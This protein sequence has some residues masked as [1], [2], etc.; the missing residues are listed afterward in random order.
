MRRDYGVQRE[1]VRLSLANGVGND[2]LLAEIDEWHK[3][4]EFCL[5]HGMVEHCDPNTNPEFFILPYGFAV[6]V[7]L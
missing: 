5:C 2:L 7:G 1:T 4:K 6:R 3:Q